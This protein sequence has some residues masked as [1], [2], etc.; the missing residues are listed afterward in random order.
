VRGATG[1]RQRA[2][3]WQRMPGLIIVRSALLLVYEP[4]RNIRGRMKFRGIW[5]NAVL[6][7]DRWALVR[8]TRAH[9]SR[10]YKGPMQESRYG[11]LFPG[12]FVLVLMFPFWLT[13]KHVQWD[14]PV[15]ITKSE[16][17]R[18]FTLITTCQRERHVKR[19]SFSHGAFHRDRPSIMLDD[20]RHQI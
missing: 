10:I 1:G 17:E 9:L 6:R 12:T 8:V 14:S 2:A 4:Q 13:N 5:K 11:A 18:L 19:G 15:A 7:G 16:P 3:P 20:L